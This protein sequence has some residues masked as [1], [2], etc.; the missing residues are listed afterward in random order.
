MKIVKIFASIFSETKNDWLFNNRQF[1]ETKNRADCS[2]LAMIRFSSLRV[3]QAVSRKQKHQDRVSASQTPP[4]HHSWHRL[5]AWGTTPRHWLSAPCRF[6]R[7]LVSWNWIAKVEC[8]QGTECHLLPHRNHSLSPAWM[9]GGL[10][11]RS[12]SCGDGVVTELW[13]KGC[14]WSGKTERLCRILI[15][16]LSCKCQ[17]FH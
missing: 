7:P 11:H 1:V 3:P 4:R 2:A 12:E 8:L 17:L 9:Q 14:Y 15:Y 5:D 13:Q 16:N 10:K 6:S